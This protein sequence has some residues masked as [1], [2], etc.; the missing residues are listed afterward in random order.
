MSKFICLKINILD[1]DE[2]SK[3]IKQ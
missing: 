3:H 2:L 1:V